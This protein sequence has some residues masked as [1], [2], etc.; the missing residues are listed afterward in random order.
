MSDHV[1]PQPKLFVTGKYG[2]GT[3]ASEWSKQLFGGLT[4]RELFAAMAMQG[5]VSRDCQ[6]EKLILLAYAGTN[7]LDAATQIAFQ[8]LA[9]STAASAIN[10][11]DALIAELS[12]PQKEVP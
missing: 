2:D 9:R 6:G 11:A 10:H 5:L 4:K 1:F 12:K 8:K 7:D 3:V